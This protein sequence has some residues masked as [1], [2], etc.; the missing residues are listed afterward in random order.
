MKFKNS[1]EFKNSMK[2]KNYNK[3]INDKLINYIRRVNIIIKLIYLKNKKIYYKNIRLKI[4]IV[5]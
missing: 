2:F 4:M 5:I 3:L 1:M